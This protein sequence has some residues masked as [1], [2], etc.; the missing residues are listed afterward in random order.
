MRIVLDTNS[1]IQSIPPHSPY[2][3]VWNSIESGMNTL[4][5]TNEILEEYEEILLRLTNPSVVVRARIEI[6][7]LC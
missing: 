7:P 3:K 6:C 4:C 5:V 1:L 2:R